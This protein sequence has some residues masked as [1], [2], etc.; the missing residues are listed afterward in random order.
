MSPAEIISRPLDSFTGSFNRP[1][2]VSGPCGVE[3]ESQVHAIAAELKGLPVNVLRGGIW[4][5]RT[6][7]GSFQ[8]IGSEGLNWLKAAGHENGLAVTVE[9]ATPDHVEDAL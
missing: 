1:F 2:L 4:K 8:G 3:S 9:V 5:P 6:R 7:P